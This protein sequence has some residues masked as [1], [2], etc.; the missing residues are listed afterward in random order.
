MRCI[1][2]SFLLFSSLWSRAQSSLT[3][4]YESD[5]S[6]FANP[7][8]GYY[9]HTQVHSGTYSPLNQL[10]LESLR[11]TQSITQILRVF[12]LESFR[13]RPISEEYLNNMRRDFDM[14]RN[15]G[16]KVIIRFA[17]SQGTSAPYDDAT[18]DVVLTHIEQLKPV[19]RENADV[20]TTWQAG[21]IGTWGEWYYTDHFASSPGIISDEDWANR[22][23][24]VDALLE[25]LPNDRSIQIRTP[26]YKMI[27]YDTEQPINL[28][29]VLSGTDRARVGHHNDCFV[30]SIND[31]GTYVNQE[32]EKPYLEAET[33]FLPMGG[34]TC[35][36]APPISD[37][38][39]ST[40]ELERFHW[41]YLNIDYNRTVLDEWENQGC[42][43]EVTLRLGYRHRLIS[44]TYESLAKPAG[45]FQLTLSMVNDGYANFY[46]PRKMYMVLEHSETGEQ[47]NL[48]V[49]TNTRMWPIGESHEINISGGLPQDIAL[50]AYNIYLHLPD[51]YSSLK[52]EP[53]YATRLANLNIWQA[54]TGFN[55]LGIQLT[56]LEDAQL[57]DYE[58]QIYFQLAE[59]F[60]TIELPGASSLITS[61]GSENISLYWPSQPSNYERIIERSSDG[62]PFDQLAIINASLGSFTDLT[63]STNRDYTYRYY[64]VEGSTRT[65]LSEESIS[66]IN[67]DVE[68]EI[69]IDGLDTDWGNELLITSAFTDRFD[70]LRAN[71]AQTLAYFIIPAADNYSIYLDTD[72]D[73]STGYSDPSEG[74]LGIDIRITNGQVYTGDGDTWTEHSAVTQEAKAEYTELSVSLAM[75]GPIGINPLIKLATEVNGNRLKDSNGVFA[76]SH[77]RNLPSDIP[78]GLTV[79]KDPLNSAALVVTWEE[80]AFCEGYILERSPAGVFDYQVIATFDK[81]DL[82]V[83]DRELEENTSYMY[84]LKSFN[85]LGESDYSEAIEGVPG[86]VT[87]IYTLPGFQV[88]PN[89]THGL[90][91]FSGQVDQVKVTSITGQI[92]LAQSTTDR[93]SIDHLSP[94]LYVVQVELDHQLG[95]YKV[96]KR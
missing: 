86:L 91:R 60:D 51:A 4:D 41:S 88:F 70:F 7:E 80:C 26:G 28:S 15:A 8:R 34:E 5:L 65:S 59:A 14:V 82:N 92:L 9:S 95:R 62:E 13:E 79:E 72:N 57:Q 52:D 58:G 66:R 90:L 43:D 3:V 11:T 39:N 16:L 46:N 12:Y 32:V 35:A 27:M 25:V 23:R 37:C 21:F 36:L 10:A 33:T 19:I 63:V 77:V 61:A 96:I 67:P 6:N 94:G 84:R 68:Q 85:Q 48:E 49:A 50:G 30:A 89:P 22:K 74:L 55:D 2:L 83:R 69:M 29:D 73:P 78:I 31:F 44:A 54:S 38:D 64:L 1:L 87:G 56:V 71:F 24:V 76:T 53:A 40:G 20:I 47:Y 75:L 42:L 18:V 17:Y 45:E 81:D 93:I